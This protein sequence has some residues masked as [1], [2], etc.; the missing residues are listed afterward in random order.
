M[1]GR[2][3]AIDAAKKNTDHVG[4]NPTLVVPKFQKLQAVAKKI[5]SQRA[6]ILF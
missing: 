5:H 1:L 4:N 6:R 2:I 3:K